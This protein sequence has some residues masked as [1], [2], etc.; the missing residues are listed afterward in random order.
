MT[1]I[2]FESSYDK[3]Y[4]IIILSFNVNSLKIYSHF[5]IPITYMPES[6]DLEGLIQRINDND[7]FSEI[8]YAHAFEYFSNDITSF[9]IK[10][11]YLRFNHG[12]S[13]GECGISLPLDHQEIKKG[14]I[15]FCKLMIE[16]NKY[17]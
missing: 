8:P 6:K 13:S 9:D 5:E 11:G 16:I 4:E 7:T 2:T 12:K 1:D 3:D 14:L 15:N 10:D 17:K